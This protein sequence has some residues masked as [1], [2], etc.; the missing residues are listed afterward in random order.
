[1]VSDVLT[2]FGYDLSGSQANRPAVGD[3][4]IRRLNTTRGNMEYYDGSQW[5]FDVQLAFATYDFAV[6]GGAISTITPSA[7]FQLPDNAIILDGMVDVVTTCVSATDA[8]TI[9]IQSEAAN[10]IVAAIAISNVANAWDA[11]LQAIIPLGTAATAI[12]LTAARDIKIVI[13]VEA[14][15]AGKFHTILRYVTTD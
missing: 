6:D 2:E 4:G 10:D 1:M 13:A 9:A 11:G 15:T 5:V 14:L 12:K 8:A 7:G 3:I